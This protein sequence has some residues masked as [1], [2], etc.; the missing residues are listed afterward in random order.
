M[1][2]SKPTQ[3]III[4][5]IL[6]LLFS[7]SGCDNSKQS[8]NQPENTPIPTQTSPVEISP[9]NNSSFSLNPVFKDERD[10]QF[11]SLDWKPISYEAKVKPYK[12]NADL[13]NI[14]NIDQFGEF[15][16][17]QKEMLSKNG[18]VVMP[19]SEEQLFYIYEQNEYL[20]VPSFITTDS[21]LQVYHIFFDYSLRTLEAEKLMNPLQN[22][23]SSMLNKSITLY[24]E[25][26][27]QEVKEAALK[28]IA[29]FAISQKLLENA[30]PENI[31]VEAQVLIN[32][33]L[34][35]IKNSGGFIKSPIFGFDVDYSQFVP[36]GHY[37]RS[38]DLEKYFRVMMWYGL[39]PMPLIKNEEI[40]KDTTAQALLITYSIFSD[41][42]GK[43]DIDLWETLY[44]PTTFYVGSADDFTIYDY[45]DLLVT[46]YGEKPNLETL[47]EQQNIDKLLDEAKKLP[48]PKI[49]QDFTS[50]NTPIGKQF[51]FM[52]QRYIPDSEILQKL[53][54]SQKRPFPK[55]LDVM[56]VLGS[57]R[58]YDLLINKYKENQAWDKYEEKFSS[59][60]Q[61][62]SKLPESTW[63][64]NMYYGWLWTLKSL[65]GNY[66]EGYP[67]FMTN[68]AWEDKSL[69]T[70]LSS[71][72][73]LRHDTI[74]YAKQSGAECGGDGEPP[75]IKGYVEPNVEVYSKL[76]WLT[77]FSRQNLEKKGIL[78]Q[79]MAEK[80]SRFEDLLQF[81]ADCSVKELRNEELTAEEYDQ[82][83]I[84]GGLLE[85]LTA[86]L[87]G[88][89]IRWFEITSETDKNMAVIADIHTVLSS[90]LEVGVG[91]ASQIY[92]AVPIGGKIY[93][94]RGAVFSYYEFISDTRLTD[95][96]W[97]KMFKDNNQPAQPD[98]TD[99]F[100]NGQKEEIP[101]PAEP[102]FSGC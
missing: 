38:N 54:D 67:S 28:N 77:R 4:G 99:S 21:V 10:R 93:L 48:E 59:L 49:Q 73:E 36:R 71:W 97:Q 14:E 20:K 41:V 60:K 19:T 76:L 56:G 6:T 33:E 85:A 101:V 50:V 17:E 51:R 37:T 27:N 5:L 89:G 29:F 9:T 86:S 55:G 52:G 24:N 94:T 95:E 74:L 70:A 44:E 43:S 11:S 69:S 32:S 79:A 88:D 12:V 15:T 96:E 81:L 18:F 78:P 31:P 23:T 102:Y 62:F 63:Q 39:I 45:K 80:M 1:K 53:V 8:N 64:S 46:V 100:T 40:V 3:I 61:Q 87:A 58:A 92:V 57:D 26:K 35:L 2:K 25:I 34:E 90:Y 83:L 13:T 68:T 42:N 72:A 7:F 84:Y 30:L 98:W 16:Q 47:L 22:L 65:L 66:K 75:I 82:L 91:P